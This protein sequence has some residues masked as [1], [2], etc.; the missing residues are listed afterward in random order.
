RDRPGGRGRRPKG[1]RA[2]GLAAE[3]LDAAAMYTS[4]PRPL[5]RLAPLPSAPCSRCLQ[6]SVSG[7]F[8]GRFSS[9]YCA[10]LLRPHPFLR[11]PPERHTRLSLA[12][13]VVN[14]LRVY[15]VT[16]ACLVFETTACARRV[17]R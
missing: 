5:P 13:T 11:R 4:A 7:P 16:I 14:T 9:P 6:R 1:Q 2:G 15:R 17:R 3:R 12:G 8:S 10:P